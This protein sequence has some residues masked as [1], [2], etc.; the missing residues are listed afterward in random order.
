MKRLRSALEP[1]R[2]AGI[3]FSGE[4][5]I[6]VFD[7]E[8][9]VDSTLNVEDMAGEKAALSV[10]LF[11]LPRGANAG[12]LSPLSGHLYRFDRS[13]CHAQAPNLDR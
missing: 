5:D 8:S 6:F 10:P 4:N 13:P 1:D 2:R 9:P 7:C 12:E 11:T 3:R